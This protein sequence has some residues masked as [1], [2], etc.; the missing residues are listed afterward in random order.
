M[1]NSSFG[2]IKTLVV[3]GS[4]SLNATGVLTAKNQSLGYLFIDLAR[5]CACVCVGV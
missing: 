4:P 3:S 2:L 5:V 1:E